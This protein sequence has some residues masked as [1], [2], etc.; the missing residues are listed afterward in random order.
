[1]AQEGLKIPCHVLCR[2]AGINSKR[3]HQ[4]YNCLCAIILGKTH[5][6]CKSGGWDNVVI[7]VTCHRV[8][9]TGFKPLLVGWVLDL[10]YLFRLA[11][12]PPPPASFKIGIISV[13]WGWSGQDVALTTHTLLG[14]RLSMGRVVPLPP[15]CL[16]GVLLDGFTFCATQ[17][18]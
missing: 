7:K 13:S 17:F 5:A 3:C 10:M 6:G 16:R 14:L 9:I 18:Y 4:F 8:D 12:R 15:L 1:M 11:P 2:S